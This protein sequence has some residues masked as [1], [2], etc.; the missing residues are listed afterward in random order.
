M[1]TSI[2]V[3]YKRPQN[4]PKIVNAIRGQTVKSEIWIWDNSGDC[5]DAGDVMIRSNQNFSQ[6]GRLMLMQAV[7][8]EYVWLNDDDGAIN[9]PDLFQK[10]IEE[11]KEYPYSVVGWKGKS[12][13]DAHPVR[14]Y[15]NVKGW[16]PSGSEADVINS[17][18][19]FFHRRIINEIVSNPFDVWA[20]DEYQHGNDM[21]ISSRAKVRS[22]KYIYDCIE[23]LDEQGVKLS[24]ESHH[25]DIRN[26]L[27]KRFWM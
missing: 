2:I 17:G 21:Y 8:S 15:Q 1:I 16:V 23:M 19:S 22:S 12:L 27:C 5:P 13:K 3:H 11:N 26:K 25:M 24:G 18:F 9:T 6:L 10:L 14:P 4:I 20:W 7:R